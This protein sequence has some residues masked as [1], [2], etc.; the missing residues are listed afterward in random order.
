MVSVD[1]VINT[2]RVTLTE[3]VLLSVPSRLATT[4]RRMSVTIAWVVATPWWTLETMVWV[5]ETITFVFIA[6]SV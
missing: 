2:I 4:V 3:R 6:S 1:S 5:S